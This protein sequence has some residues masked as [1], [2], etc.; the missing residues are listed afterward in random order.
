MTIIG[1]A[2]WQ[3]VRPKRHQRCWSAGTLATYLEI[4][5]AQSNAVYLA[6]HVVTGRHVR[7]KCRKTNMQCGLVPCAH[8]FVF[9][10]RAASN[11]KLFEK[12]H[13]IAT[14]S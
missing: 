12:D 8:A 7:S 10:Q 2:D 13:S 11:R 5:R 6:G 9:G 14:R 1:N 4:S 3:T